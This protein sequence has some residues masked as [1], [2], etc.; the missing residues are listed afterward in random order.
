MSFKKLALSMAT[1]AALGAGVAGQARA[2]AM[3]QSVLQVSN[4]TLFSAPATPFTVADFSQLNF[5]DQLTNTSN[6]NG[7]PGPIGFAATPTFAPIVDA[8]QSCIGTCVSPQNNFVPV[9]TPPVITY[10]RSDS[11]LTG[12]PIVVPSIP[13][14]ANASTI[15]ESSLMGNSFGGSTSA[16]Q[17]TSAFQFVL[18]HPANNVQVGFSA[19]DYLRAWTSPGSLPGTLA[20]ADEHWTLTLKDAAGNTLVEWNPDGGVGT[21]THT[22]LTEIADS[23]LLNRTVSAGPNSPNAP[24]SCSGAFLA[25]VNF[26]LAAN[27]LYSFAIGHS[28]QTNAVS[29]PEPGTLG[30]LGAGLLGIWAGR[31]RLMPTRG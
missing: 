7:V 24:S 9:P 23:C 10:S 27:T 12:A 5:S 15:G 4:F 30:L 25:T 28:I 2:D 8:P 19:S 21:G 6:L 14:G 20:S 17:L 26:T 31:R 11:L 22:G 13:L 3:A 1:A 29:V 18:A 16:I